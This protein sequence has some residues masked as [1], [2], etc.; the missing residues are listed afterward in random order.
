MCCLF[1]LVVYGPISEHSMEDSNSAT[2]SKSIPVGHVSFYMETDIDRI[3]GHTE[4][5]ASFFNKPSVIDT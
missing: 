1:L 4:N 3:L 2:M 5:D